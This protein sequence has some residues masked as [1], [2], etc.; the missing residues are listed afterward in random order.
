MKKIKSRESIL[1]SR[2]AEV[3]VESEN[4]DRKS[5]LRLKRLNRDAPPAGRASS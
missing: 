3:A 4:A 5:F 2:F 1:H